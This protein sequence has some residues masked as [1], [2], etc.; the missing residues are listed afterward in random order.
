MAV[1]PGRAQPLQA[2]AFATVW[3]F[4]ASPF[5]VATRMSTP[6]P[7]STANAI[8]GLP[9]PSSAMPGWETGPASFSEP[10]KEKTC[11]TVEVPPSFVVP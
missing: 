1:G 7:T 3:T 11:S 4:H 2:P 9:S 8:H 5:F 6:V 10:P